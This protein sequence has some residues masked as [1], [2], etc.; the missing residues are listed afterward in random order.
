MILSGLL[1]AL[2]NFCMR[3]SMDFRGTCRAYYMFQLF[4]TLIVALILYPMRSENAT[5]WNPPIVFLGLLTGLFLGFMKLMIDKALQKGPPGLTF[6]A[7]NSASVMPALVFVLF[8]HTLIDFELTHYD[9]MASILIV[10][11]LFWASRKD[12]R[13]FRTQDWMSFALLGF[14]FH[15]LYLVFTE[16][17]AIFINGEHFITHDLFPSADMFRSPWYLPMVFV[18]A[19]L[20]HVIVYVVSIRKMPLRPEILWGVVGGIFNGL[21]AYCYLE[22][23]E[24]A[25]VSETTLIFSVFSISTILFCN[26]WGYYFYEEKIH[27][28]ANG[29]CLAGLFIAGLK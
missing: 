3:R 9:V 17:R 28:Q 10:A 7:I 4:F 13:N 19:T 6:A 26:L 22:A 20:M 11:G 27:W 2:S 14:A 18:S 29:L 15:V 21:C 5:D 23:T 1:A 24:V 8:F 25:S 16:L 12:H